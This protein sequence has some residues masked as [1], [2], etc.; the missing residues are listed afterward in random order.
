MFFY[1]IICIIL[2][3]ILLFTSS[4]GIVCW[5]EFKINQDY[6]IRVLCVEKDK[7]KNCCQGKCHL[8]AN[9]AGEENNEKSNGIPSNILHKLK[10]NENTVFLVANKIYFKKNYQS[11]YGMTFHKNNSTL[12]SDKEPPS[13]PPKG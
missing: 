6:I 4:R 8:K 13:P 5:L 3:A 7:P 11:C 12:S 1:K 2:S 9:L 10:F